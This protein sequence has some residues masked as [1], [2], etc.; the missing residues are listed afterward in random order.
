M[1]RYI[2]ERGLIIK[3]T[4]AQFDLLPESK[5][6]CLK[7]YEKPA[8]PE[9]LENK[10]KGNDTSNSVQLQNA[11]GISDGEGSSGKSGGEGISKDSQSTGTG[12]SKQQKE[13]AKRGRKPGQKVTG[14]R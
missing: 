11:S 10:I 2:D 5:Q 14:K 12:V 1:E 7:P 13:P 9:F 8:L 4:K 6:A 3:L